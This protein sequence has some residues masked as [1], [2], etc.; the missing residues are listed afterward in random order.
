MPVQIDAPEAVE[1]IHSTLCIADLAV[2]VNLLVSL[3]RAGFK[4]WRND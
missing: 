4:F 1:K 2:D 3:K